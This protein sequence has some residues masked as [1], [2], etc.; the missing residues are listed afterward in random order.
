MKH[1]SSFPLFQSHLDLAHTY[2]KSLV[3]PG[4]TVIDATCGNGNDTL[5]LAQLALDREKEG[6]VIGIDRQIDAI[7]ATRKRLSTELSE[8]NM[9]R[10]SLLYQCHSKFPGGILPESVTLIV[11]NLGYLPG[12]NK[13]LTT[14]GSTTLQSLEEALPLIHAGGAISITCYPGHEEGQREE[15]VIKKFAKTLDPRKWSCCY[16]D[17]L[18][19]RNAP[20]LLIIQKAL[21]RCHD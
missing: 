13:A 20:S 2:W 21:L 3:K 5:I 11:Y 17:W 4:A 8:E 19:R 14:L 7:E 9:Q 6:L 12:G 10:V 18:N 1:L 16:H 15:E